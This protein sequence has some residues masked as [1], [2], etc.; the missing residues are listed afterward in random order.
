MLDLAALARAPLVRDPFE[1]LI[2]P[3]FVGREFADAVARDFPAIREPGS[4]PLSDLTYGS[5]FSSLVSELSGPEFET[6]LARRFDLPLAGWGKLVTVR[7]MAAAK[8]G[9][10]HTDAAWKAVTVLLY[11]NPDWT[12]AGGCLRLLKSNDLEQV[13]AEIPPEW[14]SLVVF[15]RSDRSFH[16]HTPYAGP[17]RLVQLNWVT[18]ARMIEREVRR[19]GRSAWIKRLARRFRAGAAAPQAM[20]E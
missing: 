17:R 15:R 4:F 8:D 11:L 6:I 16:G 10:V 3:R 9:S 14:G 7:G 5:Q 18:D 1:H 19:H 13:A 20:G 2:V 12:H